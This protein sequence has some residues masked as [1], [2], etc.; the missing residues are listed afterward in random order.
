MSRASSITNPSG[1]S[2]HYCWINAGGGKRQSSRFNDRKHYH[3]DRKRL[4]PIARFDTLTRLCGNS[5]LA[6]A[7][8]TR[9]VQAGASC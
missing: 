7:A 6:I 4:G 5:L 1:T 8:A 3:S 9:A 2:H